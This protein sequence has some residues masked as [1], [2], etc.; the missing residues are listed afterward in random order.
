MNPIFI[1]WGRKLEEGSF[2]PIPTDLEP[3]PAD[4][5][6]VIRCRRKSTSK[7][8][9]GTNLCSC[10]KNGLSCVAACNDF[11]GNECQNV[12]KVDMAIGCDSETDDNANSDSEL[13]HDSDNTLIH[14]S[15]M[16]W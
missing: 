5:L 8:K 3:A 6:N 16:D 14:D 9:C 4:V 11:H 10:R 1:K 13:E 12:Q 15:D 7:N 2:T